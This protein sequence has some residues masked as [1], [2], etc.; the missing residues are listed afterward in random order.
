VTA[1]ELLEQRAE[2]AAGRLAIAMEE[3]TFRL[4]DHRA[5]L[6]THA[7]EIAAFRATQRAAF[8]AERAAWA[9]SGESGR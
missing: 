4:A 8:A 6:A 9:T 3:G 2:Q 7:D 5:F 1:S